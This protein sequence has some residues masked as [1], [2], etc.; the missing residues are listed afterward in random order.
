M[1]LYLCT[2]AELGSGT[3]IVHH[4]AGKPPKKSIIVA[5][6]PAGPRA[7]W[8]VC[9]HLPVPLDSGTGQLAKRDEL[10]CLTHG[11]RYRRSDGLCTFGPCEGESLEPL[12]VVIEGEDIFAEV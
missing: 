2:K 4:F 6:T 10:E 1:R 12:Q 5:A 8:N 7:Y 9:Q 11:A 3:Q